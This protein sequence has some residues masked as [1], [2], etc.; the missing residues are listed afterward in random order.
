MAGRGHAR[1]GGHRIFKALRHVNFEIG[2]G[3]IVGIAGPSG[4][5]KS[6]LVKRVLGLMP[7]YGGNVRPFD[8]E[9]RDI[10]KRQLAEPIAYVPQSLFL[11]KGSVRENICYATKSQPD[12]RQMR[13]A[14]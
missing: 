2:D 7:N 10:Q 1:E 8:V 3:E 11:I 4:S 9:M 12:D 14:L 6:T 5:G 13:F